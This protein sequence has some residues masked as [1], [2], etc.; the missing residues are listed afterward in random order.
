MKDPAT[1][2]LSDGLWLESLDA[3]SE[4]GR[5]R[6]IDLRITRAVPGVPRLPDEE[7]PLVVDILS[8]EINEPGDAR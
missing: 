7:Q 3:G 4:A 2:E 1:H 5:A 8:V 6:S